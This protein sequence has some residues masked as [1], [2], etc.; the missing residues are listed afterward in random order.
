MSYSISVLFGVQFQ[1][2]SNSIYICSLDLQLGET[3]PH[4]LQ[5]SC[6]MKCIG[7]RRTAVAQV[8]FPS[9]SPEIKILHDIVLDVYDSE[10]GLVV[11]SVYTLEKDYV[12]MY[13]H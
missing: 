12:F 5:L 3:W 6:V 9:F 4:Y 7:T 11:I 8:R 1:T 13:V 2:D 10:F